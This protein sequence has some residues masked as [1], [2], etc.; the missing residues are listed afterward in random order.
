VPGSGRSISVRPRRELDG[1]EDEF[2]TI[3]SVRVYGYKS[4]LQPCSLQLAP[5]TVLAG[6]NSSGKSSFFQPI[7]LIKQTLETSTD[8][9]PLLLDG[10]NVKFTSADEMYARRPKAAE[11]TRSFGIQF[12]LSDERSLELKFARPTKPRGLVVASTIA[13]DP[14][15]RIAN[16]AIS[17]KLSDKA[18]T[19][20][21]TLPK[22]FDRPSGTRVGSNWDVTRRRCFLEVAE[23]FE[24]DDF[25]YE[26]HTPLDDLVRVV[27][28]RVAGVIHLPGLRGNPAR[29]YP[30][31]PVGTTYTGQFQDYVASI[32]HSWQMSPKEGLPKLKDVVDD[33][34][35]LRLTSQVT[36]VE[37]SDTSVELR[38]GR[39]LDPPT[40]DRHDL[41]SIADV[42]LGMS[43]VLPVVVALRVAEPGQVVILEQPELH[44]HPTAQRQLA[45]VLARAAKRGV[46]VIV[47]THSSLLL[48]GMQTLVALDEIS[49][50]LLSLNWFSRDPST[51][52]STITSGRVDGSG[53]FG[54]WPEDFDDVALQA[55]RDY[56]DA[57]QS[58]Q[59]W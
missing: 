56:L 1:Q 58:R 15:L 29:A 22:P 47:E 8:P 35:R 43:Q 17:E 54:A 40:R 44:L 30:R 32:V 12:D 10:P 5:L 9:G 19:V 18:R 21:E 25:R 2:P 36:A 28:R 24:E 41:V 23:V 57:V 39:L 7:L 51:G 20:L 55:E 3:K 42:G 33:L 14:R 46:Y 38:V 31:T 16:L 45:G 52:I 59:P 48:R 50:E 49:S 4:I 26:V 13:T 27:E 53:R 11:P 37:V 6:A 34:K